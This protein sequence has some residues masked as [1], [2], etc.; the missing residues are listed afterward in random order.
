MCWSA[1]GSMST[2]I[3]AMIL[4]AIHKYKGVMHPSIWTL[5]IVYSHMQLIEFFLW[6]NLEIPKANRFWSGAGLLLLIIQ[7]MV[8]ATLLPAGL[9]TKF[10]MT[11]ITGLSVYFLTNKVNLTTT[12]GGNG[13]LKWNWIVPFSSLWG[14]GWLAFLLVPMWLTGHKGAAIFGMLSYLASAY[15][16]DKYG[17]AGSY[18]RWFVILA[19]VTAFFK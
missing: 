19:W 14:L 6:K 13:H 8:S 3:F 12:I 10:L 5:M 4:A 11:Y 2:Y 15:F 9:R 18:W 16:N 7:P 17:T 1:N